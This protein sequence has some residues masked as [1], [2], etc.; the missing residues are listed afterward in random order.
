M[1]V[2]QIA[3]EHYW[4]GKDPLGRRLCMWNTLYTVVGVAKNT[5]H[6]SRRNAGAHDL[7]LDPAVG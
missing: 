3:A 4:P 5:A 6:L 1:I 7:Q 2:D